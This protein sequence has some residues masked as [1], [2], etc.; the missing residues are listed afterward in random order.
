MAGMM[1]SSN[2]NFFRV[3]GP[4]C[5]E[6]TAHRWISLTK[7]SATDLWCFLWA[8]LNKRLS[9]Q[10]RHWWLEMPSH[11]LWRRCNSEFLHTPRSDSSFMGDVILTSFSFSVLIALITHWNLVMC[12][13][14][15]LDVFNA[16]CLTAPGHYLYQRPLI[17]NC[18]LR[19]KRL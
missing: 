1:T 17:V 5:R 13:R 2:G 8:S 19:N 7:A 11:S 15:M 3:T 18:S 16:C 6:F 14:N 4:L 9:K 12:Q 10:S